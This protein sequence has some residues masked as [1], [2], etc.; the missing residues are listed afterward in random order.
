MDVLLINPPNNL[1]DVLGK[2]ERFLSTF[3]PIGLLYIASYLEKHGINVSVCDAYVLKM[4]VN[5]V[6]SV[7]RD[8]P[9]PIVGITCVTANSPAVVEICR[10]IR[11]SF[12]DKKIILGNLH[13]SVF[14]ESFLKNG[15]ADIIVHNEGEYT[16]LDVVRTLDGENKLNTVKG[17][18]FWDG[19][20]V[21]NN[22]IREAIADLND[23]PIPARHLVP[24]ELYKVPEISNYSHVCGKDEY[25]RG[26]FTSRGCVFQCAFCVVHHQKNYRCLSVD[27]VIEEIDVLVNKHKAGFI[28][29]H[30]PL[31]IAKKKRVYE[32]CEQMI[33]RKLNTIPW[34]C[35]AH[36]NLADYDLFC[37]MKEAG[38]V[39]VAFGIE[40]GVQTLLDNVNKGIKLQTIV[41]A[42][43]K[44]RKA[45]LRALGLFMLGLPGETKEMTLETIRFAKSLPISFA[46]FNITVPYPGSQL[47]YDLVK[48]NK[49]NT[50]IRSDGSIDTKIWE[51]YSS[52]SSYTE[53]EPIYVP[54]GYT[55]KELKK[56][57]K[58]AIRQFFFRP[59]NIMYEL[60]RVRLR[61]IVDI[62]HGLK[63]TLLS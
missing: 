35:E 8:T 18:S 2:A 50:G 30:D 58:Y 53:N 19:N 14:A 29:F 31:F 22:E 33:E 46:Q 39:E 1:K 26:M 60:R 48:E 4:G 10:M 11:K 7:I 21:V 13:A 27:R 25:L 15:L 57:H 62:Y 9:S 52:W 43:G 3:E 38:C 40:S 54:D 41:S 56:M 24:M 55:G 49:I 5:E 34:G 28:F 32:I 42:V 63:S 51:R 59:K 20:K 23:I 36:A 6:E 16:M 17:I 61:S 45:G 44:A 47:Y 12:P 37:K